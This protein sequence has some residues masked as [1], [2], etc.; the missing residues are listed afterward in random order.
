MERHLGDVITCAKFQDEIFRGYDF[1]GGRISHFPIHFAWAL[2]WLCLCVCN[3][4]LAPLPS[5]TSSIFLNF[6]NWNTSGKIQV[7]ND[8][9]CNIVADIISDNAHVNYV[10]LPTVLFCYLFVCF[11]QLYNVHTT[12]SA[13]KM[14]LRLPVDEW[15]CRWL[16]S[17]VDVQPDDALCK[18]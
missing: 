14:K 16:I 6:L 7:T 11:L 17:D 2:L 3:Y 13:Y 1:T 9:D 12:F 4:A 8:W 18:P 5:L 15:W 10:F